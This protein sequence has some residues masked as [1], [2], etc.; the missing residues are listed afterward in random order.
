MNVH[1]LASTSVP[2]TLTTVQ[3]PNLA[4]TH[5]KWITV[6]PIPK[7]QE[8]PKYQYLDNLCVIMLTQYRTYT[9]ASPTQGRKKTWEGKGHVTVMHNAANLSRHILKVLTNEK[10]GGLAVVSFCHLKAIIVS[11]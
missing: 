8:G 11:Q 4:L 6:H 9:N 3:V 7:E 5:K 1:N 10:R 2:F